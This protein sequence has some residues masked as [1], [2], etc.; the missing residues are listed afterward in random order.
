MLLVVAGPVPMGTPPRLTPRDRSTGSHGSVKLE[1]SPV[2][3]LPTGWESAVSRRTG[4]VYFVNTV[5]GERT[6]EM[7]VGP[8]S[9]SRPGSGRTSAEAS[10]VRSSARP[11]SPVRMAQAAL[12]PAS[13][14]APVPSPGSPASPPAADSSG[15]QWS[16]GPDPDSP[17][18]DSPPA[19]VKLPSS[20]YAVDSNDYVVDSADYAVQAAASEPK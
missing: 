2:G 6:F 20:D 7:P 8:R 5:T 19:V 14:A 11:V 12:A 18:P 15:Q 13:A 3:R 9:S 4:E 10:P 1:A 16:P 17:G